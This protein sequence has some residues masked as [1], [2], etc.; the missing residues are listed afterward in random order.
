[1]HKSLALLFLATTL[2]QAQPILDSWYLEGSRN[3]ARIYET[4]TDESAR[5]TVTTWS[6]GQGTQSQPTYSGV[7]LVAFDANNV[8]I[9]ATGLGSHIMGPWYGN[10]QKTQL[11]P[12]YPAGRA[13]YFRV[14]RNPA[15]PTV[16]TP[17]G[18]GAIGMFVDGVSMFDSRDAFSYSNAQG[19]DR[20]GGQGDDVWNSD[21]YINEAVTFDAANAHQAGSQYHYHANPPGLRHLLGDNV[22][23]DANSNRYTEGV[24][25]TKHSP[26][27]GWAIDGLPIYGPYG[28]SDPMNTNSPVTRM[29]SGYR[30]RSGSVR[31]TLP[32]WAVRAQN[33]AEQLP[34]NLF[35]P[36]TAIEP[37]GHY[38]EDNDYLGDVGQTLGVDFD[39]NEHNVRF[40]K[41]P[42]FPDGTWAY[43]TSVESDGTPKFPYNIGRSYYGTP[44]GGS[45]N[46]LPGT[47]SVHVKGGPESAPRFS[48]LTRN[49]G[50]GD[51]TMVWDGIEG[52]SYRI[53]SSSDFTTWIPMKV[54]EGGM[55]VDRASG[56]ANQKF[57]RTSVE[58]VEPFANAGF[59]TGVASRGLTTISVSLIGTAPANLGTEPNIILFNGMPAIFVARPSP[60]VVTLR[61]PDGLNPGSYA[62][63]VTF[64]DNTTLTGTHQVVPGNNIL[65]LIVDDWGIDS[66]PVDNIGAPNAPIM[67]NLQS[68]TSGGV[69]F[70]NAYA[71][72]QCSPTRAAI[73][74]G[75]YAF[76]TGVGSPGG[77]DF[78][79]AEVTLADA[80]V[81]NAGFA[82]GSIGKWHLG[83]G[84]T[85]PR[86]RGG[87]QYFAGAGGNL[88]AYD[89]WQKLTSSGATAP[90]TVT[91]TNYA[92]TEN[93]TDAI[94]WINSQGAS[95]WFCWIGY[96]APHSP[97]HDAPAT[98]AGL[99]NPYTA[100]GNNRRKYESMLW[101]MDAEIGRLLSAVDL[102]TT[103][104]IIIG[105]NG[106]PGG[107]VQSPFTSQHAKATLYEG[108]THVPLV[109]AG[110]AAQRANTT[111]DKIVHAVDLYSTILEIAGVNPASLGV[112]L[113]SQSLVPIL[114]DTDTADRVSVCEAFGT[115]TNPGRAIRQGDY[116][117]I[118]HDDPLITTDT[119]ILE[120]YHLPT[121]VNETNNLLAGTLTAPQQSAYD[122]LL[123]R[124]LALGAKFQQ[125]T[126]GP[127]H[128][129]R[130]TRFQRGQSFGSCP[131]PK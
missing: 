69:R 106:T 126:S 7:H 54:V 3:Y 84:D 62:V 105:D 8:Y 58:A 9:G 6:R 2:S 66:S 32:A 53:E 27:L 42:E 60:N 25:P 101:A 16:K 96:N 41:T 59:G 110:K 33:R 18:L 98:V 121:D 74:S 128:L 34:A 17:T 49:V 46:T 93:T 117:L 85:G 119:A 5:T 75:R 13:N 120:L 24:K 78:A 48:S 124:N 63:S 11:F 125:S 43:F 22:A 129:F 1:M 23:Y 123:A 47:A 77:V 30:L 113:D 70:L 26:I 88:N 108:G 102:N 131:D 115:D 127:H 72:A 38:L 31:E 21:A 89:N 73:L 87:W 111:S 52:G 97:F 55:S 83:G 12:S 80:L 103:T 20:N 35:G 90:V 92:T 56:F 51:I 94:N 44:N 4:L 61:V 100:G 130:P 112:T 36:T 91:S 81:A 79:A 95:N 10:P 39:L 28:Y 14:T 19:G 116:K 64:P 104:V 67:P 50:N 71:Q 65:L 114:N 57:Y 122:S 37:L 82:A 118:I 68:L 99:A 45:L 29:R 109:I 107:V 40:G 15:I 86:D 76:R